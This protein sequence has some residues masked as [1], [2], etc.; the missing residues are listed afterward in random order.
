MSNSNQGN[1]GDTKPPQPRPGGSNLAAQPQARGKKKNE[2][3][4]KIVGVN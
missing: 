2:L 4:K 3:L 1:G